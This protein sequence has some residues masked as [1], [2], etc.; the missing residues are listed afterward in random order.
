MARYLFVLLILNLG[1]ASTQGA[2]DEIVF[3]TFNGDLIGPVESIDHRIDDAQQ[4]TQLISAYHQLLSAEV[5]ME[6]ALLHEQILEYIPGF[7][8]A[9]IAADSAEF[10]HLMSEMDLRLAAIQDVHAQEYTQDVVGLLTEAYQQ[11][12]PTFGDEK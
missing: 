6:V 9:Y 3:L 11:I 4:A 12:L 1:I 2:E 5:Q 7:E 10:S 8:V